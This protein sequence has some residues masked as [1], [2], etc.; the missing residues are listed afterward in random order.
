MVS[1]STDSKQLGYSTSSSFLPVLLLAMRHHVLLALGA[2]A[3][4]SAT[5]LSRAAASHNVQV[6]LHFLK[7]DYAQPS[8][9]AYNGDRS[10]TIG[11]SC[12]TSLTLGA[13]SPDFSASSIVFSVDQNGAGNITVGGEEFR[14]LDDPKVSGGV[15]CGR[16]HSDVETVVNCE[17]TVPEASKLAPLS[18]QS[19][20]ECISKRSSTSEPGLGLEA[21]LEGFQRKPEFLPIDQPLAP[22]ENSTLE[23][24]Q[25]CGVV[26]RKADRV[27]D[28]NPHQNPLN[29]QL[30]VSFPTQFA[31][32]CSASVSRSAPSCLMTDSPES[33]EPMECGSRDGCEIAR[34]S[35][36]SYSIGWSAS[37]TAWSWLSAGFAV[38]ASIET[39]N[40]Y[41]CPGNAHDYFAVWKLQAQTAYTVV[42]RQYSCA[43]GRDIGNSYVMWSPN[44]D[45]RGGK[46]YCVYGRQYVRWMGDRWLDTTPIPGGPP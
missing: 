46:Y 7:G 40:N 10:E 12:S 11:H 37:A 28:G 25:I 41:A 29:I 36:R 13:A 26:T 14:V 3:G 24:R 1:V 18:R 6:T 44:R 43:G 23:E 32:S 22:L 31:P 19:L 16:L 20:P 35:S 33:Q 30:S 21:V 15:V 45:N 34:F 5:P 4:A 38:E 17:V 39:G 9:I 27:G 42:N 2:S 8:I